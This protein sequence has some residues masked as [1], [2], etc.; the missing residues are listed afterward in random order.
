VTIVAATILGP[1]DALAPPYTSS[2][3]IYIVS[4]R[5]SPLTINR[6]NYR[7]ELAVNCPTLLAA[8]L[9]VAVA[10]P[11]TTD[12]E[13]AAS[14]Q[15]GKYYLAAGRTY[16]NQ[17]QDHARML[18]KYAA[19]GE[20]V[21]ANIVHEH[22]AAIRFNTEGARRSY[23]RLARSAGDNA[24]LAQQIKQLQERLDKVAATLKQL[25]DASREKANA[26]AVIAR[27][28]EISQQLRDNHNDLRRI[29]EAYYNSDSD[30]YYTTGEGHFVD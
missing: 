5:A 3:D 12:D 2:H 15:G 21:P 14:R 6:S 17:A 20:Q 28:N 30:S 9:L 24:E 22:A 29:D 16:N 10:N 23:T 13:Y 27:S 19:L 18:K 1:W 25:E 11:A 7:Q 8:A 4:G 26:Q